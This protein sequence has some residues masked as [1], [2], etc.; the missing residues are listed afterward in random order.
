MWAFARYALDMG[1]TFVAA[2]ALA[3]VSA[4]DSGRSLTGEKL[5]AFLS[6]LGRKIPKPLAGS[7]YS[8]RVDYAVGSCFQMSGS[9][10]TVICSGPSLS[11]AVPHAASDTLLCAVAP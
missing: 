2:V 9:S 6:I 4:D 7:K 3:S 8:V 1:S 10:K 5:A 11:F